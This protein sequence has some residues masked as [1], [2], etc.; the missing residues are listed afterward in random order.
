MRGSS[1]NIHTPA[2][3]LSVGLLG[4]RLVMIVKV[5]N[6]QISVTHNVEHLN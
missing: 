2:E 4:S 3:T 5:V 6:V 1:A